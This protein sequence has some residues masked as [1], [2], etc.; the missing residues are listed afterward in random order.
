MGES[1]KIVFEGLGFKGVNQ[2]RVD[3]GGNSKDIWWN[4]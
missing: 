4:G 3:E 1:A 2:T